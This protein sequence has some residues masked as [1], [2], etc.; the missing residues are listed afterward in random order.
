ML[1]EPPS[2][3]AGGAARGRH[4]WYLQR[5]TL[6]SNADVRHRAGHERKRGGESP[7]WTRYRKPVHGERDSHW[8]RTRTP[9]RRGGKKGRTPP[10]RM[11]RE[12]KGLP[13]RLPT[14]A[15]IYLPPFSRRRPCLSPTIPGALR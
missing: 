11:I 9:Q 1:T 7:P 15:T 5:M 10:H 4:G 13:P 12:R 3:S 8:E 14:R 6:D 2:D